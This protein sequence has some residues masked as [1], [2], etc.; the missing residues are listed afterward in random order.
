MCL[1]RRRYSEYC[2]PGTITRASICKNGGPRRVA[3]V[4]T[5]SERYTEQNVRIFETTLEELC[6]FLGI[7][8]LMGIHELPKIR[9]YWSV[10]EGLDNTLI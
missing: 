9:H 6:A 1:C 10:Y 7:I 2:R 8:I 4:K 3:F 5:E